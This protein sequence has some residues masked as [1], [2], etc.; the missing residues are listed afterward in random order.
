M[1][2]HEH[3][4]EQ[5]GTT[6]AVLLCNLTHDRRSRRVKHQTQPEHNRVPLFQYA[7]AVLGSDADGV[8]HQRQRDGHNRNGQQIADDRK[9][10]RIRRLG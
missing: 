2:Q 1:E 9:D 10:R 5:A 4:G 3:D 7:R 8:A 6:A